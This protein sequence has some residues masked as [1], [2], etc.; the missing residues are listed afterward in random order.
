[1]KYYAVKSGRGAPTITMTWE[2]CSALVTGFSGAVYKS[3]SNLP[4]ALKYL[5]LENIPDCTSSSIWS[6]RSKAFNDSIIDGEKEI[7][8]IRNRLIG[9]V[10]GLLRDEEIVICT[11]GSCVNQGLSDRSLWKAGSGIYLEKLDLK[12]GLKVTGEQTNNRGELL[13]IIWILERIL[14]ISQKDQLKDRKIIIH[15]DSNYA[16]TNLH[17]KNIKN[18][19]LW[20]RLKDVLSKLKAMQVEVVFIKDLAH[21]GI[22]GNETADKIAG[23][24]ATL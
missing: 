18:L 1:M 15:S 3:F 6:E 12:I 4:D 17:S 23:Y 14:D 13:P 19:D 11:D 22:P 24:M 5:G 8:L 20:K 10:A 7:E 21:S 2:E 9:L 16:I